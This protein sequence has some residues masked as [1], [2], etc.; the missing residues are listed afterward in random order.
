[1]P[2]LERVP[3]NATGKKEVGFAAER[4]LTF[5]LTQPLTTT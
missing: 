2:V 1:V 5:R 3:H 4:R